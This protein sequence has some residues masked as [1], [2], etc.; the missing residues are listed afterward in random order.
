M[1]A[2]GQRLSLEGR[3]NISL[4]WGDTAAHA[5]RGKLISVA[6]KGRP[7]HRHTE[8][9]KIAASMWMKVAHKTSTRLRAAILINAVIARDQ[10]RLSVNKMTLE[11]RQALTRTAK[12]S[13]C[14]SNPSRLEKAVW[15]VL[16]ALGVIYQTSMPFGTYTADIYVPAKSLVI[17]C[18]GAY[19]HG[20][21]GA[22][23]KDAQRDKYM[24]S[25]GLTI[26]RLPEREIKN[27]TA[28]H[29]VAEVMVS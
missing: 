3:R 21:P 8:A 15:A 25:L 7:G 2:K 10:K 18:D 11:E 14:S 6:K 26:L 16:D 1:P 13:L 9:E 12:T 27:G 22:A 5:A 24:R 19:W 4:S 20:R 23:E 28:A 29:L 17:E